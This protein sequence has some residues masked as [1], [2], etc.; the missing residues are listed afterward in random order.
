MSKLKYM[1]IDEVQLCVPRKTIC[2]Q[3]AFDESLKS[4]REM[5]NF[6][7]KV[8]QREGYSSFEIPPQKRLTECEK[9]ERAVVLRSENSHIGINR[10]AETIKETM[11]RVYSH[12]VTGDYIIERRGEAELSGTPLYSCAASTGRCSSTNMQHEQ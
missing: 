5:T 9:L 4:F 7:H 3:L 10:G 8:T 2:E 12:L 1:I 6:T 11:E